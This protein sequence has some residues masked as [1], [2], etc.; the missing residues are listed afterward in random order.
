MPNPITNT[1]DYIT[2]IVQA[3]ANNRF[4]AKDW[5]DMTPEQRDQWKEKLVAEEKAE[6]DRGHELQNESADDKPE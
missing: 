4:E 6:I 2:L 5:I 1:I 3:I